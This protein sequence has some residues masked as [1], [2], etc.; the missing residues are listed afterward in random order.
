MKADVVVIGGGHNGLVTAALLAKR[1]LKP[2]VLERREVLGG[3]AVTEEFHPGFKASTV[4]HLLGPLRA[5]VAEDL[6]L[7]NRGLA[8]VEPEPRVYA[9]R[10]DGGGVALW[11]DPG[12]TAFEMRKLSA[13]DA[14]RYPAFHRSLTAIAEFLSKILTLTPPD[15]D[16]P[17]GGPVLPLV[18]LGMGFRGLGRE[19]GQRLLRWAPMAVADFAAE[20]FSTEVLRALV[21]GRGVLGM[22]AGPWSAGT[23]ANLLLQAAAGGGNGA[24]RSVHVTGGLGALVAALSAAARQY[25]AQVRTSAEVERILVKDGTVTGVVLTGGEE[26]TARAVVSSA[27]PHRTF[28]K[29]VDPAVLDPDDFRRIRA[30]RQEGMASKVNLALD[31]LPEWKGAPAAELLRGRIHVAA[32]VDDIERAFDDAKY[33]GISRRPFLEATIPSLT[34]PTA[35]PAGKHVMSVYVQ[36]TPYTLREGAWDDRRDELGDAVLKTLEDYAPGITARVLHRQVLTPLDLERTYGLTGGHPS[37]GEMTL[38]QLFVSRPMLG[39]ARYR[40]PLKGLYMCGAGTH[41]GGG[42]TGGPGANAAQEIARDLA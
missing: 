1:G 3:A 11:G 38:D 31:G 2:L 33:G 23:T 37:H 18:G 17:L 34:D 28:L 13:E 9:P 32:E 26:I 22:F 21:C 10:P 7:A 20:W 8:F 27:D 35:A 36:Y 30:W 16:K 42:V 19:D 15:L 4:A 25:G 40:G 6:D 5:S 14:E 39:W 24:G 41:P 12:R 29:M